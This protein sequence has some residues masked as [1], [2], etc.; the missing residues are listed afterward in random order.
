[1]DAQHEIRITSHGKIHNWVDFAL[2]HF[3]A[4]PDEALVLHTLPLPAK[5][6]VAQPESVDAKSDRERLPHSVAN[7]PRLI[8]VVE[9]IKREYLKQLDS[10][11]QDH[12]KLSGLYQYN[13]I[14][15]LPDPMEEGDVAGAEQ[16]RVQALANALQGKKHLKIKKSPYMKVILSRRELDDAH[17]RAFTKQPPSIRKL[18]RS[19]VN[20]AK[21]R[22]AKQK[23]DTEQ[24]MD[25]D[26]DLS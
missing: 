23:E 24:Q 7:V 18:P 16:A 17:L 13:E 3:E 14:G 20:R 26:D 9:I 8:S 19:T 21:R 1:M 12:G 4:K 22:Q 10:I 5:D 6:T 11:H 25:Q 2:K 15:S